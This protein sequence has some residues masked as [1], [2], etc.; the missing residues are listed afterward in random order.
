MSLKRHARQLN[1]PAATNTVFEPQANTTNGHLLTHDIGTVSLIA[2]NT[3]KR[4]D[5]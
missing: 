3:N 5:G 2:I 4:C 1:T